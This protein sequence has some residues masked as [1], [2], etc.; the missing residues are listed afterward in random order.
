VIKFAGIRT[1]DVIDALAKTS[2]HY[3][4]LS[5]RAAIA[6]NK[7]LSQ[8]YRDQA[9]KIA[10]A[11]T[12]YAAT[13]KAYWSAIGKDTPPDVVTAR[14]GGEAPLDIEAKALPVPKKAVGK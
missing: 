12:T 6:G 13:T 3:V 14:G 5:E 9:L 7:K 10:K 1:H 8:D 11:Q 4:D 2:Q